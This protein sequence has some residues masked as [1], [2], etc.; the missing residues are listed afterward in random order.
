[1][2]SAVLW[3]GTSQGWYELCHGRGIYTVTIGQSYI[4]E[5]FLG[6]PEI[7]LLSIQRGTKLKFG[8][9]FYRQDPC[10]LLMYVTFNPDNGCS[11]RDRD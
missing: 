6:P 3:I 8:G 7:W 9:S 11:A 5:L 4:S 1:M 10:L 2:G